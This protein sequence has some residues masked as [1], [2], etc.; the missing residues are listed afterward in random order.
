MSTY[1]QIEMPRV[2]CPYCEYTSPLK[3]EETNFFQEAI[4]MSEIR[5][6]PNC[7]GEFGI[8]AE[9]KVGCCIQCLK[10][11]GVGACAKTSK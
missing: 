10:I 3:S 9:M 5:T 2:E 7:S 1:V 8:K 4:V 6:C 11:E